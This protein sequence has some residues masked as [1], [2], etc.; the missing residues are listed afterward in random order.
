[1]GTSRPLSGQK[2]AKKCRKFMK[3]YENLLKLVKNDLNIEIKN[4]QRSYFSALMIY[5]SRSQQN[6]TIS[7]GQ[8]TFH[9]KHHAKT[10]KNTNFARNCHKNC[11]F[12]AICEVISIR[13]VIKLTDFNKTNQIT[14]NSSK[15]GTSRPLTEQKKAKRYQKLMKINQNWLKLAKND[16]DITVKRIEMSYFSVL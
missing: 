4:V 3:N 10:E 1:M 11:P 14:P 7:G 6:L 9:F 16:L 13:K 15:L 8:E 2:K 12:S 5:L